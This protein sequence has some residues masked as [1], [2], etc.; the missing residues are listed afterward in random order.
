MANLLGMEDKK[1]TLTHPLRGAMFETFIVSE[2]YKYRFNS[3]KRKN[4]YYYRDN[5]GNEIDLI[6][7]T[8]DGLS[9]IEIK[10]SATI[11]S[12][13]FKGFKVFEKIY[14]KILNKIIIYAGDES[15]KYNDVDIF[16]YKDLDKVFDIL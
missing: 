13:Y 15:K 1:Q 6:Y 14:D 2:F 16:S 11:T 8:G 4:L 7:E 10:S 9:L 3:G 5:T 12:D